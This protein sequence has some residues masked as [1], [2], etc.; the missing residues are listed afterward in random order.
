ML[1]N[2]FF[3]SKFYLYLNL[4]KHLIFCLIIKNSL[5]V[6]RLT[7]SNVII[8]MKLSYCPVSPFVGWLVGRL[9]GMLACRSVILPHSVHFK[10]SRFSGHTYSIV[11][12][13]I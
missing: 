7:H 1:H 12:I 5:K 9:A 8:G 10:V 11:L 4:A 6:N 3:L 2:H 13:N